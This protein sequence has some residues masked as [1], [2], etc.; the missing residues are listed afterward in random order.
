M[1]HR[2]RH[3][4]VG[5][6]S[7]IYNAFA[8]SLRERT[9]QFGLLAS[10]GATKRQLSRSLRCEALIVSCVG[11]PVGCVAGNRR[12]R[13]YSSFHWSRA[14][15]LDVWRNGDGYP[16]SNFLD[17]RTCGG[18]SSI[19]HSDDLGVDSLPESAEDLSH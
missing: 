11:I 9:V 3:H 1:R 15:K 2:D 6:V 5:A 14:G 17:F 7:L 19:C 8:I 4:H 13:D 12:D 16:P 10:V 18:C